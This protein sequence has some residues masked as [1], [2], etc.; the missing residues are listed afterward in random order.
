[1]DTLASAGQTPADLAS[2]M[3]NTANKLLS[4]DA[5]TNDVVVRALQ[6]L[7]EREPLAAYQAIWT[8]L[9]LDTD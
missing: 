1:M 4:L 7:I 6:V 5:A 8:A 9:S 3:R 2:Q